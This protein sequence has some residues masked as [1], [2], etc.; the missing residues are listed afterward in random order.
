MSSFQV[1]YKTNSQTHTINLSSDSWQKVRDFAKDLINGEITEI[2]EFI[3]E[4]IT[5][6]KDDKDYIHSKTLTLKN[7][8]AYVSLRI[9]KI[10]KTLT[11]NML[12]D[13]VFSHLQIKNKKPDSVKIAT[14]F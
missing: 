5:V 9:P 8:L 4:D 7:E 13:L 3:H 14:K 2:R 1:Q 10:K 6:K 11:D 12:N